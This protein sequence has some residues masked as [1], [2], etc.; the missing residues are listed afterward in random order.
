MQEQP[1]GLCIT[2][3]E[4]SRRDAA[5]RSAFI[6]NLLCLQGKDLKST[7]DALMDIG[8]T[9]SVFLAREVI[10]ALLAPHAAR[11]Q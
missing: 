3:L 7:L 8:S 5:F 10:G 2:L 11:R 9:E 4:R 1:S 6:A